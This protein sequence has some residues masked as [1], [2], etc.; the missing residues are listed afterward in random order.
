[1][2]YVLTLG[3]R[4]IYHTGDSDHIPEMAGIKTDVALLPVSGIYVM[5]AEEAAEAAKTIQPKVAIPMHV[6]AGIGE[7]EFTQTFKDLANVPV[8]ILPLE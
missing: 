6:G 2:G 8:V 5:T 4:R 1:M 7:L 3:E